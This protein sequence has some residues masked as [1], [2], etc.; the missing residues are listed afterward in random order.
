MQPSITPYLLALAVICPST[1]QAKATCKEKTNVL[2]IMT[3]EHNLRTLGCYRQLMRADQAQIWGEGNVVETPHLDALAQSGIL[4]LSSYAACPISGPTRACFQSGL[5]AHQVGVPTNDLAMNSDVETFAEVLANNGYSTGYM[6]KWHLSGTGRPQW[7]PEQK[8]GWQDNRYMFNRGHWKNLA[9]TDNGAKVGASS[10]KG[11]PSYDVADADEKSFTTDFLCDRA[12]EFME[13]NKEN[14]FCCMISIPDPHGPNT[15]RKPYDTMFQHLKFQPPHTYNERGDHSDATWEKPEGG[16]ST[17]EMQLYFGMVKC[18][19]DNVGKLI[20][21][22]K[23][24]GLFDNTLI[25]FTSDHGDLCG[26]H[27][28]HNKG[29]PYEM[30]AKVP[31]IMHHPTLIKKSRVDRT[32]FSSVDFKPT[33]LGLLGVKANKPSEGHDVSAYLLGKKRKAQEEITFL[34]SGTTLN[35][36]SGQPETVKRTYWVAAV[37]P[38]YKLICTTDAAE[39]TWLIDLEKDPN[40]LKNL[41]NDTSYSKIV[42]RLSAAL[43]NYGQSAGDK[44][45]THSSVKEKLTGA[46]NQ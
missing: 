9:L 46:L 35:A 36:F 11:T 18:I 38:R 24:N 42:S 41:Y 6:G 19:D 16:F 4:S 5:Y 23:A 33:L 22:M 31:F 28:R 34:R 12:I 30:S 21:Y 44:I 26:E 8:F 1:V 15:V 32:A 37:T 40:E 7:A 10:P 25:I 29:V 39:A 3:D 20:Q 17:K 2:I 43:L 45:V 13:T 14:P 27:H